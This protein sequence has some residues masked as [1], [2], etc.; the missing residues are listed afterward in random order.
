MKKK[1]L[2]S[3]IAASAAI[4]VSLTLGCS[5]DP[6]PVSAP[7]SGGGATTTSRPLSVPEIEPDAETQQEGWLISVLE[8]EGILTAPGQAA[9]FAGVTCRALD[10]GSD[11][12]AVSLTLSKH[13]PQ[14]D[15]YDASFIVGA[16]V[17]IYCPEHG[18]LVE[19]MR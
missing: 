14:Y 15:P 6:L 18:H 16:S 3:A 19:G 4:L 9:D 17:G 8:D 12:H 2:K 1:L 13:F 10:R 11:L 7:A 5:A